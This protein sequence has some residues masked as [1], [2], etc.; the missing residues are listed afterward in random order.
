MS[1]PSK[2]LL[3]MQ[4]FADKRDFEK[5][6]CDGVFAEFERALIKERQREGIDNRVQE[7]KQRIAL[8]GNKSALAKEYDISRQTLYSYFKT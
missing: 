1:K 8:G 7:L 5:Y 3:W 4:K 6:K 2:E